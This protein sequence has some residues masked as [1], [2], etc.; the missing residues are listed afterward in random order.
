MAV[1]VR[2]EDLKNSLEYVS[3]ECEGKWISS[4]TY[5]PDLKIK[6]AHAHHPRPWLN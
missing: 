5:C 3:G 6:F 1:V 4:V 2:K